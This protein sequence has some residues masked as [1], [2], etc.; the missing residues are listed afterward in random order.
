M[1]DTI[2]PRV[3]GLFYDTETTGFPLFSEPSD[4]HRQPHIVQLGALLVDMQTREILD[5]LDVIVRPDDWDIPTEASNVHGISTEYALEHGIPEKDAIGMLLAM[6]REAP[7]LQRIGFNEPFDARILRIGCFRHHD[8]LTAD[9]WKS[10]LAHDVMKLCTPICKLPPTAKMIA[11]RRGKQ[12]KQP[13]LTEAHEHF[14]GEPLVGAHSA[15]IDATATM[16]IHFHLEDLAQLE[17]AAA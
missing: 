12:F 11:A 8:E 14:F 16:R 5:G 9:A 7:T 1:N 17:L 6:W 4:D 2:R 10:G 15:L 13:K 3:L